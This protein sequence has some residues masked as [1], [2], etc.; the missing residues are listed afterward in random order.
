MA[1]GVSLKVW[2]EY[3][4]F[5][6]PEMKVERVSYD[7][8]TPSAARGIIEAI[9]WKP[10]IRWVVD[11]ITI[12]NPIRFENIR[13][14]ELAN[15]LPLS[16]VTK[17]MKDGVSPVEKFIE[18]DRQQRASLVLRDVRYIIEAHFEFTGPDDNNDGK[19]LDI[20]NR[21]LAKGQCFHRPCLGC[22]EF[23]AHFGPADCPDPVFPNGGPESMRPLPGVPDDKD[24][25]W[26]LLDLDYDNDMEARFF[27]A[28]IDHGVVR[29]WKMEEAKA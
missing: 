4:C 2:G 19:H 13:R 5:T 6:R 7:V 8:M 15:K 10:A 1:F 12:L 26:M 29:P 16:T 23:A 3:A 20:F 27:P 25:G 18:T 17:A 11:A 28:K 9:Y 21:R 14:N 24:L 22:R